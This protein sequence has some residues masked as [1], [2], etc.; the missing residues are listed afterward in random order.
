ML[1]F[2]IV[3]RNSFRLHPNT[4][5]CMCRKV[6]FSSIIRAM[7]ETV[8]ALQSE[9]MFINNNIQATRAPSTCHISPWPPI[10]SGLPGSLC[11]QGWFGFFLEVKI[12]R[13]SLHNGLCSTADSHSV[14]VWHSNRSKLPSNSY[15]D[16]PTNSVT[17]HETLTITSWNCRGLHNSKPYILDL[18]KTCTDII[19]LQE[20]WLWPF[21]LSGLSSIHP[22]YDFTAILDKRLHSVK[23]DQRKQCKKEVKSYLNKCKAKQERRQIS[24]EMTC[25][26]KTIKII[27]VQNI[28]RKLPA[29]STTRRALWSLT[30]MISSSVGLT[31]SVLLDSLNVLQTNFSENH[32]IWLVN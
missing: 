24:A 13:H 7:K 2:R 17:D 10:T 31:T 9:V 25:F 21:D 28:I 6:A 11:Q 16:P 1:D 30:Q 18:I 5:C 19:I 8:R 27:S 12:H 20:H 4:G 3:A 14:R 29:Q 15:S 23:S 32:N 26:D 22:Q